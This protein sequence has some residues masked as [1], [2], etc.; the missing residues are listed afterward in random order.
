MIMQLFKKTKTFTLERSYPA[1][2]ATV[3]DAWTKAEMVSQWWGPKNTFVPE[4]RI[5]P[6]VGGE[7]YIVM[8]A[9]EAM[10]KYAGTRW[11][12]SGVFTRV[13]PVTRMT[14]DA[15]SWTAG[16]EATSSIEHTN[17]IALAERDGQTVLTLTV[18][19]TNIGG[20]A[21]MA[22]FGMKM[23][24]KAQLGKLAELLTAPAG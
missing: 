10:G 20:K 2:V 18:T 23:G 13:D 9:G 15:R 6:Q 4:C 1:P 11:P 16:E 5:D 19:I 22:A 17:D 21:K 8:E 7:V 14:Y 24:Y 3:W 12:M